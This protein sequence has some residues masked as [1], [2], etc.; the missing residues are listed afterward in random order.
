MFVKIVGVRGS[1]KTTVTAE[2]QHTLNFQGIN[3]QIIKGSDL[4][5]KYLGI[6][7][8]KLSTVPKRERMRVRKIIYKGLYAYDLLDPNPTVR[9][10]DGHS[11]IVE[12]D[13]YGGIQVSEVSLVE[14][15]ATQ[16][17]AI[18]LLDPS[19]PLILHRRRVD[20]KMRPERNVFDLEML[21]AE[22][23][24]ERRIAARQAAKLDIPLYSIGNEKSAKETA[25]A[26][27]TW[28]KYDLQ[29]ELN[30][31]KMDGHQEGSIRKEFA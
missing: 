1:G 10:R 19:L 3:S 22:W 29:D 6:D 23:D 12:R 24:H 26:L 13:A 31:C 21:R 27:I 2:M 28:M 4:M 9:L 20:L 16:L 11:A 25:E 17:K 5:A 8:H 15:D 18:C 14:G 7:P 30:E